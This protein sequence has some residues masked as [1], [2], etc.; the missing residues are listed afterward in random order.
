VIDLTAL[1]LTALCG[2]QVDEDPSP[3]TGIDEARARNRSGT[4]AAVS[5][6]DDVEFA[7][8]IARQLKSEA[9]ID[10]CT[11][12]ELGRAAARPAYSVLDLE[13]SERLIGPMKPWRDALADVIARLE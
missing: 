6:D 2:S 1:D 10:S 11:T 8:E 12:A 13:E 7:R 9:R 4:G 5:L 3:C